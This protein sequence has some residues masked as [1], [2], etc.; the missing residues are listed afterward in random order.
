MLANL[1]GRGLLR[2]LTEGGPM[3]HGSF[4]DRGLL[5][6]LCLTIAPIVVGGLARRIATG[7]GQVLTR[8]RCAHMLTD[9]AGY[10][11]TRYVKSLTRAPDW[12]TVVGMRRH[13]TS[14]TI[15]VPLA[16]TVTTV[17]A[18]CAP[19]LGADPRFATDSGARPQGVATTPKPV[20]GPPPIAEPKNDL[21]WRD[22]TSRVFA[23]ATVSAPAGIKLDCATYDSDLDP[24]NGS[25]GTISIGV[26]RA[27]S[28]ETP[29]DA[30]P[31]V[32]TTG[33][34]LPSSTQLPVWLTRAGADVLKSNP[35]SPSIVAAWGCRARS[36]A[37]IA[38]TAQEM[39]DQAQFQSGDDPVAN[40]SDVSQHRDH[41]LHRRHRAR[42][43][44]LRQCPCRLGYRASAQ[45]LGRTRGRARRN[46]QRRPS[47]AGLRRIAS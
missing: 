35:S 7:P 1:A 16:V 17:L 44:R 11:Y 39:R 8:M 40:L 31:L 29:R 15:L 47:G 38:W 2:V 41:R 43:L 46:R 32:F 20:S 28:S 4:I 13:I 14:A 3:L 37:A 23:D 34:D 5:D 9:D 24:V 19:G 36:T 27:R 10:L 21:S 45:A 26:V 22:C 42:R 30:G 6:D 18:G 12:L 25:S 33:S